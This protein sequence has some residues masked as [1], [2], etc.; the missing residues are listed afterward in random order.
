VIGT[1][2]PFGTAAFGEQ[3]FGATPSLVPPASYTR[4]A[5]DRLRFAEGNPPGTPPHPAGHG[6]ATVGAADVLG[7]FSDLAALVGF[8]GPATGRVATGP[9]TAEADPSGFWSPVTIPGAGSGGWS[10]TE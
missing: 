3:A 9:W 7:P 5:S 6:L 2:G 8:W 4:S 1:G 10:S